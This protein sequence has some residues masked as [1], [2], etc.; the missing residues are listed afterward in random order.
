MNPVRIVAFTKSMNKEP[1]SGTTMNAV[2]AGP[3][4]AGDCLHVCHSVRGSTHTESTETTGHNSSIVG[5]AKYVEYNEV[6]IEEHK[7][8]LCKQA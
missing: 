7:Y 4:Y 1:T 8:C 5:F 6:C 2:G 3:Y